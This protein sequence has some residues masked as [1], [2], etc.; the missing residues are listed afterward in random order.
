MSIAIELAKKANG[1]TFPNPPVGC[2]IVEQDKNGNEKIISV[3]NT[4][5]NGRPHAEEQAISKIKF[6][7]SKN[8]ICYTTLEPCNHKSKFQSCTDRLINSP[9][10]KVIFSVMDPDIRTKGKGYKRLIK[11]GISVKSG[12]LKK[13]A[14][15]LYKGYFSRQIKLKPFVTLKIATSID[16]KIATKDNSIKWITNIS[17]RKYSQKLR[18]ENDAILIGKSTATIDNP[19][20]DCRIKGLEKFSPKVVLISKS[21]EIPVSLKIFKN[22]K[23]DDVI[24]FTSCEEK[25][26]LVIMEKISTLITFD[27]Y[28][29]NLTNILKKLSEMGISNLLVE[30]GSKINNLFLRNQKVDRLMIFRGNFFIGGDGINSV[31]NGMEDLKFEKNL[32]KL[33]NIQTFGDNHLE[34]YENKKFNNYLE[35]IEENF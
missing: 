3:G 12:L 20:L 2:V 35:K 11:A 17:A 30:G 32:F 22:R 33:K 31:S 25:K 34:F 15:E 18:F 1:F 13:K 23:K 27:I 14:L 26:K 24:I 7:K 16:G 9:I 8:Y 10:K 5:L 4:Q 28:K 29:F 6:K 21:L 19:R